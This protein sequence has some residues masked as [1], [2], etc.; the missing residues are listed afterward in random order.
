MAK[1]TWAQCS[2]M[3]GEGNDILAFTAGAHTG[4]GIRSTIATV[5]S[6]TTPVITQQATINQAPLAEFVSGTTSYNVPAATTKVVITGESNAAK[7]KFATTSSNLSIPTA[8][9]A[10]GKAATNDAAIAG[11]PGY[12]AKFVWSIE[13]TIP[14]NKTI[15]QKAFAMTVTTPGGKSLTISITQ[16]AAAATLVLSTESVTVDDDGTTITMNLTSNASWKIL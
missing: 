12:A 15:E 14:Q 11:D 8:Y 2:P 3:S 9:T 5:Q 7:L 4:R 6:K 1:A 16:A 13:V 10:N